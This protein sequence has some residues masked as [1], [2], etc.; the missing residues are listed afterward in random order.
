M[1]ESSRS[2]GKKNARHEARKR[3]LMN[4]RIVY[5]DGVEFLDCT[6]VDVS[7][8]G[9][10]VRLSGN[11]AF[12]PRFFLINV[13]DHKAHDAKVVWQDGQFAGVKFEASYAFDLSMPD[14]LQYLRKHWIECATR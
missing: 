6:I 3:A 10:R 13:R 8:S 2:V 4:A 5:Q 14:R 11:H 12:P 9:A 7:A 1:S